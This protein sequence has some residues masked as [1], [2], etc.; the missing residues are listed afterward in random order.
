MPMLSLTTYSYQMRPFLSVRVITAYKHLWHKNDNNVARIIPHV[1]LPSPYTGH[2]AKLL[3]AFDKFA[4]RADLVCAQP[5]AE[6]LPVGAQ[7][8]QQRRWLQN[9]RRWLLCRRVHRQ[10]L[11]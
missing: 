7:K 6:S 3:R 4:A 8:V 2:T 5:R 9:H 10:T 11:A 1:A